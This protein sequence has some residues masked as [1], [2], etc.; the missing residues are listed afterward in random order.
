MTRAIQKSDEIAA[1]LALRD[2]YNDFP[3]GEIMPSDD[4]L[5]VTLTRPD[6]KLLGIEVTEFVRDPSS[7]GSRFDAYQQLAS[8]IASAAELTY[9]STSNVPVYVTLSFAKPLH[10]RARDVAGWG[11]QIAAAVAGITPLLAS[12]VELSHENATLPAGLE[13]AVVRRIDGL[14]QPHFAATHASFFDEISPS[15]LQ[16]L[17]SRKESRVVAYRAKCDEVWLLV[18]FH[19]MKMSTWAELSSEA[20]SHRYETS[21]DRVLLLFD[22][23]R[24]V[25]LVSAGT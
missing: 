21:F 25:A 23:S 12:A 7:K 8:K 1:V 2:T 22:R 13:S 3:Q 6:G 18:F 11:R 9:A 15:M 17:L 4:P 14:L 20:I 19:P 24:V 16:N 5:D 10:C